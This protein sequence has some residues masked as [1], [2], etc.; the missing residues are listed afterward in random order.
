DILPVYSEYH[1]TARLGSTRFLRQQVETF[2][3]FNDPDVDVIFN[4]A[5][6]GDGKSLGG[7]LPVFEERKCVIAMYPTNELIQDQYHALPRY[8]Q[9]LNISLPPT[10]L[11]FSDEITRLMRENDQAVR[12]EAVRSLLRKHEMLLTNPDLV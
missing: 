4:M 3:A 1:P 5:M 2:E 6:T 7:Y 8:E 12:M 10:A 9:R 11:M